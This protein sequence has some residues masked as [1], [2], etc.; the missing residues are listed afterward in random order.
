MVK[1][2]THPQIVLDRL[3]TC[4]L[5][6]WKR[7]AKTF[8]NWSTMR[9]TLEFSV[10]RKIRK[11]LDIIFPILNSVKTPHTWRSW[12]TFANLKLPIQNSG[13]FYESRRCSLRLDMKDG[14]VLPVT[15]MCVVKE[16]I[17]GGMSEG[18][19]MH[20]KHNESMSESIWILLCDW[21]IECVCEWIR[22][23][24]CDRMNKWMCD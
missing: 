23:R 13:A 21:I 5:A 18:I 24:V 22:N 10:Y 17:N 14:D 9:L 12:E 6:T 8:I 4:L 19:C 15:S 7:N 16:Y 2:C 3:L 1:V 20:M 11:K